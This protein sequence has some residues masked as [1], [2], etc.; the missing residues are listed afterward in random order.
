MARSIYVT[1]SP[2]CL[3]KSDL[4]MLRRRQKRQAVKDI[5]EGIPV[6][7]GIVGALRGI[8]FLGDF[9]D[10]PSAALALLGVS[11]PADLIVEAGAQVLIQF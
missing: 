8:P 10:D 6:L 1:L 11:D 4:A 3:A 9:L 7:G 2:H 5:L